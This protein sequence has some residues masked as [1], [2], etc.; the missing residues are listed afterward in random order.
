MASGSSGLRIPYDHRHRHIDDESVL[1]E[2]RDAH[3]LRSDFFEEV[4]Q[5]LKEI[6]GS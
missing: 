5:M 3:Q 6:R 2:F 1:Y 4:D